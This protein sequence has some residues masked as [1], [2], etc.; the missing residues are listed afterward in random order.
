MK[1]TTL[2]VYAAEFDT[3]VSHFFDMGTF[4]SENGDAD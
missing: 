4:V 3:A 2:P 1:I